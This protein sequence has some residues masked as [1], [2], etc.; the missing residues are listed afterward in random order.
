MKSANPYVRDLC[1]G[2]VTKEGVTIL[3]FWQIFYKRPDVCHL[4]WPET[5]VQHNGTLRRLLATTKICIILCLFKLFSKKIVWTVHN[6]WPHVMNGGFCLMVVY[7]FISRTVDDL[8]FMSR[9]SSNF[10]DRLQVIRTERFKVHHIPHIFYD[11]V[12]PQKVPEITRIME[13]FERFI[14]L[15]GGANGY[16]FDGGTEFF[17]QTSTAYVFAGKKSDFVEGFNLDVGRKDFFFIDRFLTDGELAFA[18]SH[19]HAVWLPYKHVTNS[20]AMFLCL[21]YGCQIIAPRFDYFM[22][23]QRLFP[24]SIFFQDQNSDI[25]KTD[26]T[27]ISDTANDLIFRSYSEMYRGG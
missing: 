17:R 16:R 3:R 24:Q 18:L 7:W 5:V 13:K 26:V 11:P 23:M 25:G 14:F 27:E 4:H 6:P 22:E 19:A 1:K 10:L 12:E 20:G 8:H 9:S 21:T 15:F 2:L